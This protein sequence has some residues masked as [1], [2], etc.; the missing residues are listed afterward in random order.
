M[1]EHS[2]R[3]E[4]GRRI[5][6][7]WLWTI[8]ASL[9]LMIVLGGVVRLT[10]SGLSITVWEPIMGAIPPLSHADWERAFAL[11]RDS[12][13]YKLQNAGM[14]LGSFQTI[15][16]FEYFHRLLGRFIGVLLGVPLV[17]FLMK[18]WIDKRLG[19]WL[20]LLFLLGA[21]QG[22]I[23]WYMVKSG[24][25]DI[26]RVSHYRLTLHLGLGFL[27]F[28]ITAWLAI[29]QSFGRIAKGRAVTRAMCGAVFFT[30]L[31]GGL[32]AG[33]HAG[34]AY[35]TFPL[36]AGAL[37]PSG[38][39][40]IDPVWR[41]FIDSALTVQF[42][43]RVFALGVL[44]FVIITWVKARDTSASRA[45][46]LLLGVVLVQVM[47]GILTLLFHVPTVLAAAHQGNAALLIAASLFAHHR[48][49]AGAQ[50]V[51]ATPRI[52]PESAGQKRG[53]LIED[54]P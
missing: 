47:L 11:Y 1:A 32:V 53:E 31:S 22:F 2:E 12:P 18:R 8:V 37:I 40:A 26:P 49:S 9:W 50:S 20:G 4:P 45:F 51:P 35:P 33:L 54:A 28:A 16:W 23:G 27:S 17:V 43:H 46:D 15:F 36:I 42:Q 29:E 21:F 34:H 30:A 24:L 13:Q 41:N 6:A 5:V 14:D 3:V 38:L 48:G 39:F 52:Q 19:I 7:I 44:V 10:G 25:V